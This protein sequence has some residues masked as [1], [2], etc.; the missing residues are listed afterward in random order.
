MLL[1]N[2]ARRNARRA[3]IGRHACGR[4]DRC[5]TQVCEAAFA[6]RRA[7]RRRIAARLSS[8]S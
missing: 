3:S 5:A 6:M 2:R 7:S 4:P 1:S 8:A